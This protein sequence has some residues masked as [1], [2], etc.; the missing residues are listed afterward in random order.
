MIATE[1]D[2]QNLV[3][4]AGP[5]D[6]ANFIE[7][8]AQ[9]EI[10][11]K[12]ALSS[13]LTNAY[14]GRSYPK[15]SL[16][17]P[18]LLAPTQIYT[19]DTI[20]NGLAEGVHHFVILKG[21]QVMVTTLCLALE[22]YWLG[23][24]NGVKGLFIID[25]DARRNEHREVVRDMVDSLP[26]PA[27]RWPCTL[28]NQSMCKFKNRSQLSFLCANTRSKGSLGASIG[29]LLIHGS[30]MGLWTD[31]EGFSS[32]MAGRSLT[33]PQRLV[34]LEGTAKGMGLWSDMWETALEATDQ[35]AIFVGWWRHPLYQCLPDSNQ[36]KVYWETHPEPFPEE[37]EW[38]EEIR[39]TYGY[40]LTPEQFAWWRFTLR[41]PF[42]NNLSHMCQEF[43]PT[44][45]KA[46]Q[47]GES[48]FFDGERLSHWHKKARAEDKKYGARYFAF[49]WGDTFESTDIEPVP[50]PDA[51]G[52]NYDLTIWEDPPEKSEA[53][54]LHCMGIDPAHGSSPQSDG[55]AI[56]VF[57]CYAD[58]L[59][60][61]AEFYSRGRGLHVHKLAWA[62]IYLAGAYLNSSECHYNLELQ[63]GGHEVEGEIQR[64]RDGI[65][66]GIP[67]KLGKQFS[68]FRPYLYSRPDATRPSFSVKHTKMSA[69]IKEAM[70]CD[71]RNYIQTG[72]M[73]V[74]SRALLDE[75]SL[76]V[77]TEPED[78]AEVVSRGKII[79]TGTG[80]NSKMNDDRVMAAALALQVYIRPILWYIGNTKFTRDRNVEEQKAITGQT[81]VG[82]LV[83]A[84]VL[85]WYAKNGGMKKK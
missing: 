41:E 81:T 68:S 31:E 63:G 72:L 82:D 70:L 35:Y 17:Y 34:I 11:S 74:R 45:N 76:F 85:Q 8:C 75:C 54:V 59:D 10:T 84:R 20:L 25:Q 55:A 21:R 43:P 18:M 37:M 6:R 83:S 78:G 23:K 33:S 51:S 57:R 64:L 13:E 79:S 40:E 12:E 56:E 26:S 44:P 77:R 65:A 39:E 5:I 28:F 22:L 60:Q 19:L 69:E 53:G 4:Q 80:W 15:G 42:R 29:S 50:R 52:S 62:L 2:P 38:V 9:C 66:V 58:G 36:Y 67:N 47:S 3:L 16:V 14:T 46:F 30:E 48:S 49:R 24:Y 71:L 61:V 7:F 73:R 27:W 32:L 1:P